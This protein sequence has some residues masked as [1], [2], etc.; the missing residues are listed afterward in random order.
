VTV[1]SN[2][3]FQA[4]VSKLKATT[5]FVVDSIGDGTYG[6]AQGYVRLTVK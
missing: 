4:T 3:A 5:D 1:A 6:G 2:G